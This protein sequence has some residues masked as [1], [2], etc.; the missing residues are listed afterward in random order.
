MVYLHVY[1]NMEK[2]LYE[3][4]VLHIKGSLNKIWPLKNIRYIFDRI[5]KRFTHRGD[6]KLTYNYNIYYT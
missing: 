2:N 4:K 5:L 3:N 6:N 1:K